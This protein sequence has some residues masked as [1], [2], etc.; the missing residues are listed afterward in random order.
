MATAASASAAPATAAP[1]PAAPPPPD[2]LSPKPQVVGPPCAVP[3][4]VGGELAWQEVHDRRHL[5]RSRP[6]SPPR[7]E[8][9]DREA[10]LSLDFK[11]RTFGLCFRCMASDHFVA[12]CRG[13]IRCLGCGHSGHRERDCKARHAPA[14]AP[15]LHPHAPPRPPGRPSGMPACQVPLPCSSSPPAHRPPPS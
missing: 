8:R 5:Q 3:D 12:D 13:S 9:S 4:E 2:K 15:R 6:P 10:G 14:Q 11:R 7:R 1:A